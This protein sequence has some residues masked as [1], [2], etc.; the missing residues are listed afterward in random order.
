MIWPFEN[1]TGAAEK[2]IAY[3]SF[4]ADRTRNIFAV[5]AIVLTSLLFSA[6]FTLGHG[7]TESAETANLILSGGDGHASL[8]LSQAESEALSAHPLVKEMAYGRQLADSVDN[9]A[10][11]K[12]KTYFMYYDDTALKYKFIEPDEGRLPSAE[13]EVIA[14]TKTLEMLGVPCKEGEKLSLELSV[15]GQKVTRDFVLSGWWKSYPGV[16]YGTVVASQAYVDAHIN[17]FPDTAQPS[18]T[19]TGRLIGIMKFKDTRNLHEDLETVIEECGY[20]SDPESERY[21]NA[22]VNPYY[23]DSH[24]AGSFLALGFVSLMFLTVGYLIINNIF[25]ISVLRDMH[26][27]GMLKT[28]GATQRQINSVI[29]RQARRLSLIGIPI[30]LCLGYFTGKAFLPMFVEHTAFSADYARV[31]PDP[32]VF[33]AAGLFSLLT[34]WVS[35]R[36]PAKMAAEVSPVEAVRFTDYDLPKRRKKKTGSGSL[37]GRI[38]MGNLGRNRRRTALVVLSLTLSIILTNTVFVFSRSV[39]PENAIKNIISFDYC[40]AQS[41]LMDYSQIDGDSGLSASFMEAVQQQ[42]GFEN[43]GVEYGCKAQY[44][45]PTTTQDFNLLPDGSFLTHLY[46]LDSVLLSRLQLVD[47]EI[48]LEKLASGNYILEGAYVESR[49]TLD[50]SSINHSVGDKLVLTV[51]GTQ[52]E[53]TVLGH[54]IANE[55]NTYDW[56]GSC[57]FLPDEIYKEFTGISIPMSYSFD[58]SDG[59]EQVMDQFLKDYTSSTE[60][61]MTYKSKT[62]IMEGTK[63]IQNM[64]VTVGGT[65]AFIVGLIGIMNY[66]NTLLTGIFTRRRELAVLQSVGMTGGQV[67]KMLRQEGCSY[68]LI[69]AA[70][71]VPLCIITEEIIVRPICSQIWFLSFRVSFLPAVV[72]ILLLLGIGALTPYIACRTVTRQS[73]TERL[74]LGE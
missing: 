43:G 14:D 30:G 66:I 61:L 64:V 45:S 59:K 5:V 53:F 32:A 35:V 11:S 27:Y 47:G 41:S 38:A 74:K 25:R 17:E 7:L 2:K 23:D 51:G 31:K 56:V 4:H 65:M 55:S 8:Y 50:E 12:R 39:D 28:I 58:V 48:D 73:I 34:V 26:F 9:A 60:P 71:T 57:F 16:Q 44:K 18:H 1:D 13:N 24:T 33:I 42:E 15:N 63:E 20:S 67:M 10:L 3:K 69:S 22:S 6:L 68:V 40:I 46:G 72:L 19:Y 37:K 36:R 52:R 62:T 54:I 70:V 21:I 29:R 49:G